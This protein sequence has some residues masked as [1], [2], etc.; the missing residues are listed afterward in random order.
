M[1]TMIPPQRTEMSIRPR[2]Y[3]TM[4]DRAY[5]HEIGKMHAELAVSDAEFNEITNFQLPLMRHYKES[6]LFVH[7]SAGHCDIAK[8]AIRAKIRPLAFDNDMNK[9]IHDYT[10]L[11]TSI[12]A[13]GAAHIILYPIRPLEKFVPDCMLRIN[14]EHY[15]MGQAQLNGY[16]KGWGS[17]LN[18]TSVAQV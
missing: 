14:R 6:D 16:I 11:V 17:K 5:T 2:V 7:L 13:A 1:T 10:N 8:C 15:E 3:V 18:F 4:G 9:L 12:R